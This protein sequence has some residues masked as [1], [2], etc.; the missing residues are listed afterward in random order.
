MISERYPA[1]NIIARLDCCCPIS[2]C[3]HGEATEVPISNLEK[4]SVIA[5]SL[6]KRF[7]GE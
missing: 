4:S 7:R 5:A 1:E 2:T 6:S 3:I